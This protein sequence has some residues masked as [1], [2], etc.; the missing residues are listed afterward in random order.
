MHE[1]SKAMTLERKVMRLTASV[2]IECPLPG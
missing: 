2:I 1:V